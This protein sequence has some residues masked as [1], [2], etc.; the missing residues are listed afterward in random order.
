MFEEF[1]PIWRQKLRSAPLGS[2]GTH[3]LTAE[4][5]ERVVNARV[6]PENR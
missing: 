2:S 5:I 6:H 4:E 1:N 3:T